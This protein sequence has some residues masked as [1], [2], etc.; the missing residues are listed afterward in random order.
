VDVESVQRRPEISVFYPR[1]EGVLITESWFCADRQRFAVSR[2]ERMWERGGSI[3]SG[4]R[5]TLQLIGVEVLLMIAVVAVL[6]GAL[7]PSRL[8]FGLAGVNLGI[9]L[10]VAG[11]TAFVWPRPHEL[12]GIYQGRETRLYASPDAVEFHKVCRAA[13]RAVDHHRE[14]SSLDGA[15]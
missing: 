8:L 6:S 12:W 9:A 5:L 7:G 13:R 2:L 14:Q 15:M 10:L 3:Q 1:R 11:F 4:R